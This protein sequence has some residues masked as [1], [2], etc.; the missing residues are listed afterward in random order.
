MEARWVDSAVERL[1]SSGVVGEDD[2][3]K[4]ELLNAQM[5]SCVSVWCGIDGPAQIE[6][7][8]VDDEQAPLATRTLR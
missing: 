8:L 6:V 3:S 7:A 5:R 1:L 4:M 2:P